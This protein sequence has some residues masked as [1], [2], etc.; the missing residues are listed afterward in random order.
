MGFGRRRAW[1]EG[2]EVVVVVVEMETI[3]REKRFVWWRCGRG[4]DD[5]GEECIC[6]E[7]VEEGWWWKGS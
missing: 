4:D 3:V 2:G 7:G 1:G 6:R 5:G